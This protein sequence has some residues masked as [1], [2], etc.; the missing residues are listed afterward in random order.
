MLLTPFPVDPP[1]PPIMRTAM[2][3]HPAGGVYVC[4]VPLVRTVVV[5][6]ALMF[7]QKE[8]L[9]AGGVLFK[10]ASVSDM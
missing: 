4:A 10:L 9:A 1:P 6:S 2:K 8:L 3:T 5:G 7:D